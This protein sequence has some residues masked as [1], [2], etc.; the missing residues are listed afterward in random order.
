V[1][2]VSYLWRVLLADSFLQRNSWAPGVAAAAVL[3]LFGV[4]INLVLRQRDKESKTFDYRVISDLPIL[5]N[6]PDNDGLKITYLGD[7]VDNPR[8]VRI[9]FRNT[10]KQVIKSDEWLNPY[11]IRLN[12]SRLKD[13]VVTDESANDL[14]TLIID[15]N[16]GWVQLNARTL[17]SGASF[18]VQMIVDGE[19]D[20]DMTISGVVVGETRPS[21]IIDTVEERNRTTRIYVG[22]I[23][24]ILF[25][26][27]WVLKLIGKE[28]DKVES[29]GNAA[30]GVGILVLLFVFL[31]W[32]SSIKKDEAKE[33]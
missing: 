23:G 21:K 18:T 29:V 27:G 31:N 14:A 11:I 6:R 15:R 25:L 17:N 33:D 26:S 10:G 4:L 5:S 16:E 13:A 8:I 7:D 3:F 1:E 24:A 2:P 22:L 32:A 12:G 28:H 20:T 30:L 19:N 9:N